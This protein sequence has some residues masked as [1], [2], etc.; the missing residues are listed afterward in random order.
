[1]P[2]ADEEDRHVIG[3]HTR[4]HRARPHGIPERPVERR[5][6]AGHGVGDQ[7]P[8]VA[9]LIAPALAHTGKPA[10]PG[11]RMFAAIDDFQRRVDDVEQPV[12]P[13]VRPHRAQ[14]RRPAHRRRVAVEVARRHDREDR[15]ERRIRP[16]SG[17]GEQLVDRQVGHPEHADPP[18]GVGQLGCPVDE[19]NPVLRL[20]CAEHL[21]GTAGDAAPPDVDHHL[22][23]APLDQIRGGAA[24]DLGGRW[25]GLLA[26]RR[27]RHQHGERPGGGPVGAGLGGVMNVDP[28]LD[29]VA[30]R[31]RDVVV[32]AR[33]VLRR[34]GL[35]RRRIRRRTGFA[36]TSASR[37]QRWHP[38]LLHA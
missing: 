22:D 26:V 3:D 8:K 19:L 27:H 14:V 15:L 10:G 30:H 16:D 33:S 34:P 21:E 17:G 1:M 5:L 24:A 36:D 32:N 9:A 38:H 6:A 37:S 29:A 12:D 23:V 25:R 18:V 35:P 4:Q 11:P 2:T 28:Q 13:A 20:P 7:R 31:H